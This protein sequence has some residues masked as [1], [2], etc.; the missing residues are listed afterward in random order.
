MA[1]FVVETTPEEREA[2][3]NVIKQIEGQTVPVRAIAEMANMSQSRARYALID[4][5]EARKIERVASKVINKHYIRYSYKI[6]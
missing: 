3:L 1:Q 6:L 4:L 2:I 5:L